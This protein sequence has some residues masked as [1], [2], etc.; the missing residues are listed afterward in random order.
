MTFIICN[1]HTNFISFTKQLHFTPLA[2]DGIVETLTKCILVSFIYCLRFIFRDKYICSL[3]QIH[4]A[5]HYG[6]LRST[7]LVGLVIH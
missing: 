2:M 4:N 3:Q 7:S 5:V 1:Q 6:I